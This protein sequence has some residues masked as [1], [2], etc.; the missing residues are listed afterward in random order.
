MNWP[1]TMPGPRDVGTESLRR[2]VRI[3][4][5]EIAVYEKGYNKRIKVW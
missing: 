3:R 4:I 1:A 5:G 2:G